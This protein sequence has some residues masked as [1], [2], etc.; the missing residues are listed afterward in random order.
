MV[1]RKKGQK[2]EISYRIASPEGSG[3]LDIFVDDEEVGSIEITEKT[4]DFQAWTDH[5]EKTEIELTEGEH[6]LKFT[7]AESGFNISFFTVLPKG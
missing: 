5:D 1:P 3:A 7:S 6:T 2:Y 4:G